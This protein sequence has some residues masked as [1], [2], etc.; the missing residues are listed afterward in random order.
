MAKRH[1]LIEKAIR[2]IDE[3]IAAL[4]LAREHLLAEQVQRPAKPRIQPVETKQASAR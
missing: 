4:Q 1:T 3:K 2:N